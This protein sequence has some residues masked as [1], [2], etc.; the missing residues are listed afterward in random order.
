MGKAIGSISR[1][2]FVHILQSATA[3]GARCSL[4]IFHKV[5]LSLARV[6]L[7]AYFTIFGCKVDYYSATFVVSFLSFLCFDCSVF[8]FIVVNVPFYYF[9]S[10]F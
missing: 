5:S 3:A 8:F 6:A 2:I 7:C 9:C 10:E 4:C 1:L